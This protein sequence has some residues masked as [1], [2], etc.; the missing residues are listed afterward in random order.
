MEP[1]LEERRRDGDTKLRPFFK[2]GS[3]SKPASITMQRLADGTGG[4]I[5]TKRDSK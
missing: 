1:G 5:P 2:K 4:P 3:P